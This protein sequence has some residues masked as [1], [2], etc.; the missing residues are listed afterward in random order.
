[1]THFTPGILDANPEAHFIE[2]V[3]ASQRAVLYITIDKAFMND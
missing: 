3:N 2:T 1:M